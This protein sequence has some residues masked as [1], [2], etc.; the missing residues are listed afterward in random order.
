MEQR[1][2]E[3]LCI[4]TEIL[5]G[6]IVNTNAAVIA[7]ELAG[8][9]INLYHQTVVGDNPQ[10]LKEALDLAFSRAD[11]VI[12]TGGLGPTYDDLTKEIIAQW[13]DLPLEMDAESLAGIEDFFKRRGRQMTENNKK[14]AMMPKGCTIFANANGTAPGCAI[15]GKGKTAIMMPGP[16]REM[17]PM[18]T[19]QVMPF[20][21]KDSSVRLVSHNLHFFEIGESALEDALHD[22]MT[23][24]TNPTIA[25]YAKT[26]EVMLRVTAQVKNG[27]DA[28]ALLQPVIEEIKQ[29]AGQ[30]LYG[31]DVGDLQTALVW[32]LRA[33]GITI[34]TAESCT[35]GYVAKRITDVP[36]ASAAFVCGL[37]T[38][39]NQMKQ[40]IL[41]VSADTLEQYTAISAQTAAEMAAG[42][43]RVSGADMAISITGN[44]G[45][46]AA[47][48]KEVGEVYI[49]VDSAWHSQ[50][51]QLNVRRRDGDTRELIRYLAASHALHLALQTAWKYSGKSIA[52]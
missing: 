26:G 48:G 34:A 18:L 40:Q 42:A 5:M 30:Y 2:A 7:K 29:A 10:R 19:N 23:A 4:G 21:R 49:A 43:R 33:K 46:D 47:D 51:L 24:S 45:P 11:I 16:P 50:V 20:L 27:E 35:G 39:T 28:E 52:E 32:E 13:F 17:S 38:Y 6:D 9:G 1:T 8:A 44:A 25:P 36:G 12:T 3:I 14:Q 37:V 15:E 41:G 31:I 22:M